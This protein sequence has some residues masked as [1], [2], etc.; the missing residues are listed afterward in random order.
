MKDR[1]Q[2]VIKM[3]HQLFIE[4]GFQATSIQDILEYS[5]ISK[6]TFYNY[7]SSKNELL[8]ELIKSIYQKMEKDRNDLLVGQDPSNTEIFIEQ[9]KLQMK[10]N[11]TYKLIA[12]FEEVIVSNDEDLKQFIRDGQLRL[13][14]WIY[15]RFIDIFGVRKKSVL[16]D[17]SIMFLGI[18]HHNLRYYALIYDSNTSLHQVVRYSV[19]RIVKMVNEVSETE[20]Q[21]I[22]PEALDNLFPCIKNNDQAYQQKLYQT[23]L[24][25]KKTLINNDEQIKYIELLDFI[26]S[27]ILNSKKPRKYLIESALLSLKTDKAFSEQQLQELERL[28]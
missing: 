4:K 27:E 16:L 9:I 28:V 22:N 14:R 26:Q 19:N 5:G 3:A 24:E 12:L 8:I 20:E 25:L 7:F 15:N 17:C 13:V 11:R 6:G 10:T 18:L 21:L 2:H 1:K 23:I